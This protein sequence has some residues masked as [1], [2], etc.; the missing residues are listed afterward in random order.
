MHQ[1]GFEITIPVVERVQTFCALD[2]EASVIGR[3]QNLPIGNPRWKRL[4]YM[5]DLQYQLSLVL[6]V[7]TE[8][9]LGFL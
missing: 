9:L 3:H 6:Q 8:V 7:N 4:H 2:R 1:V 5:L